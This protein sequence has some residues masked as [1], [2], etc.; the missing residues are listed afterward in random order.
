MCIR[1][2]IFARRT[3]EVRSGAVCKEVGGVKRETV[4]RSF[5]ALITALGTLVMI[6]GLLRWESREPLEWCVFLLMT[7]IAAGLRLHVPN[8]AGTLSV[9]F[10]FVLVA[11]TR[12][13]L[14]EL[15]VMACA[16]TV[17]QVT[18]HPEARR[19]PVPAFFHVAS[20]ASAVFLGYSIFHSPILAG[21]FH[22]FAALMA[23][24]MALFVMKTFPVAAVIAMTEKRRLTDMW[25]EC[26]FGALPYYLVGACIAGT[27]HLSRAVVGPAA[28][29]FLMPAVFVIYCAYHEHVRRMTREK[30]RAEELAALHMRTIEALS[31]AIEAKDLASDIHLQRM[32]LYC[33]DVGRELRLSEDEI[34]ALRAAAVLHDVGTLAVPGHILSKPGRLTREEFEK[35]KIHPLVGAEILDRVGFPYPVSPIVRCHHEKWNGSGYPDG[36][37]GEAIPIGARILAVVDALDAMVSERPHRPAAS[38]EVA[39]QRIQ[40]EAG[41]SYDPKVVAVIGRRYRDLERQLAQV[42]PVEAL[43]HSAGGLTRLAQA[44]GRE[45]SGGTEIHKPAFLDTIAAARQEAQVLLELEQLLGR[46]LRLDDTLPALAA[47]LKRVLGFSTLAVYLVEERRLVPRYATG[48]GAATLLARTVE[49]GTGLCGWVAQNKKPILNGNP[50]WEMGLSDDSP[51]RLGLLN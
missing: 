34:Q 50:S 5:I 46:S 1:E 27:F 49:F 35:I 37:T 39:I 28:T 36:L 17:A 48:D 12:L 21:R 15:L 4:V 10:L 29:L 33:L 11:L 9:D 30:N 8:I 7:L 19:A 22:A 3:P 2:W 47:A 45:D 16:A 38:F 26:N 14:S 6:T 42:I 40:A 41:L 44:V 25:R 20:T 43:P 24:S 31:S 18:V 51:T 32:Q 23:A 13:G